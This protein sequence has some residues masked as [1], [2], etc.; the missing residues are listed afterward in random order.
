TPARAVRLEFS[1]DGVL[2]HLHLGGAG[3]VAADVADAGLMAAVPVEA[4]MGLLAAAGVLP[5]FCKPEAIAAAARASALGAVEGVLVAEGRAPQHGADASFEMLVPKV[6]IRT[7]QVND[8][9]IV[10]FRD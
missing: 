9:D 10:D 8:A 4:I 1:A 2:A 5:A 3:E 7:P 6:Q